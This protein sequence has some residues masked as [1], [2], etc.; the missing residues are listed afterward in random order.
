MAT[1]SLMV[2]DDAPPCCGNGYMLPVTS[3]ETSNQRPAISLSIVFLIGTPRV[4]T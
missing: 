1:L 2:E 4:G 3:D